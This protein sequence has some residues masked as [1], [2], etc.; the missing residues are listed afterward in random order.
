MSD[1][2]RVLAGLDYPPGKRAEAGDVVADLPSGS[3]KWLEKQ[4]LIEPVQPKAK[5]GDK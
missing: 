3:I 5:A 1:K 2:Y 4:G